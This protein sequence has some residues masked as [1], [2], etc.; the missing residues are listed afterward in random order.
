MTGSSVTAAQDEQQH[1]A[2]A[3]GLDEESARLLATL[4]RNIRLFRSQRGMTRKNLAEQSG[5]SLPHLARL[6]SS[7]GNVS[8]VV[9][10]KVARALNQPLANLFSENELLSG[11]LALIVEFLRQQPA[12]RL[13][14]IREKLFSEFQPAASARGQRIALIGLRG[15]GKAPSARPWRPASGGPSSSSTSR[16]SARPASACRRSSPSTARPATASSRSAASKSWPSPSPK[17][18]S[19]P[20][21]ASS[22]SRKPTSCCSAP[23]TPCG[24]A[25]TR[26]CISAA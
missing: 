5:V 11:D 4:A 3:A 15:A 19:P 20:A 8:V 14:D 23:S 21:A 22:S 7:Q 1:E 10:G 25:P 6:E 26:R 12:A 16:S 13:T 17:W 24:C 9:L 2:A 18:C